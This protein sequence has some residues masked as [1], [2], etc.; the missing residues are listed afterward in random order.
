[1]MQTVLNE[2]LTLLSAK[3]HRVGTSECHSK[4]LCF[5]SCWRGVIQK[6]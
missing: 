5:R 6:T 3:A 1:M 2:M 4:W